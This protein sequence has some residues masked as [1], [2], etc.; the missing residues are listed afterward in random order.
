MYDP[1]CPRNKRN[2][3][4]VLAYGAAGS[5]AG[6]R[7]GG[8]LRWGGKWQFLRQGVV[9]IVVDEY[10]TSITCTH[11]FQRLRLQ[12]SRRLQGSNIKA[13]AV[14]GGVVCVNP[15]CPDVRAGY[16]SRPRDSNAALNILLAMASVSLRDSDGLGE[17]R[18]EMDLDVQ[19]D[20]GHQGCKDPPW[21][22]LP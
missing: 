3:V 15:L 14:N 18:T 17:G 7:I 20:D 19:A 11:C 4:T 6:S 22:L 5:G 8:H 16:A 1:E 2:T 9:V 21:P 12:K 13:K 10:C